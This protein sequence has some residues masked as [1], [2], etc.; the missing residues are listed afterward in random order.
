VKHGADIN[1]QSINGETPLFEACRSGNEAIL[2]YLVEHGAIIII[3]NNIG[4]SLLY[5]AFYNGN[6]DM[7][8]YL[9]KYLK[10][11]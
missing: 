6:I 8:K 3:K 5:E 7:F 1:R 11:N 9:L 4:E 10:K 2:K